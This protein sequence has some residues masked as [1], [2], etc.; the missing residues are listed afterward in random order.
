MNPELER[1]KEILN[2][3]TQKELYLRN[4]GNKL[5]FLLLFSDIG[6]EGAIELSKYL[7]SNSSLQKLFLYGKSN[8]NFK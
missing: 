8:R 2:Q 1:A 6:D 7:K 4:C 3:N 5:Y